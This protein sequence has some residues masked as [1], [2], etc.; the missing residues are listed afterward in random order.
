MSSRKA[1]V[2][3]PYLILISLIFYLNVSI[4]ND[5]FLGAWEAKFENLDAFKFEVKLDLEGA[6][7]KLEIIGQNSL[8]EI[9][10]MC[11]QYTDAQNTLNA[12]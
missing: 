11:F 5:N 10:L 6:T 2:L 12:V 8:N 4:A 1:A 9:N 3:L 7:P